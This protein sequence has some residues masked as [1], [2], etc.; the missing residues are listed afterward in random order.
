[1]STNPIN[2]FEYA[3]RQKLEFES[4]RGPLNVQQLWDVP[5]SSRDGF[6]LDTIAKKA[7]A[8][9]EAAG[10][11]SFVKPVQNA[12]QEKANVAFELV[13]YIIKIKLDEAEANR[14][15]I[16]R[17]A[18]KRALLEALAEKEKGALSAMSLED[19]KKRIAALDDGTDP[20]LFGG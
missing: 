12:K 4:P 5:L 3:T 20:K 10:E 18:E 13:L 9:A 11:K 6:D 8:A 7:S 19:I 17:A 2:L 14:K 15:R 16:D 1:M